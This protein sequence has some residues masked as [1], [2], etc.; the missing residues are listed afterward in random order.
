MRLL[1]LCGLPLPV[2]LEHFGEPR[3]IAQVA[4][5]WVCAHLPP[6]PGIDLHLA[7]LW[8]GGAKRESFHYQGAT[9]HLMPCPARGRALTLFCRDHLY[10]KP[11][12]DE[13]KPDMIH[14]W[15]TE[16]SYGL[17]ALRLGP[18]RNVIG[19][20]GLINEYRRHT[21]MH[22]RYMLTA[23]TERRTLSR[24]R[25]VVAE[26]RYSQEIS[27]PYAPHASFRVVEHPLRREFLEHTPSDGLAEEILVVG[28]IGDRKGIFD[29]LD[30]FIAAAPSS[31]RLHLVGVGP[32]A[33]MER[34]AA[35][36]RE[37]DPE[38]RIRHSPGLGAQ[39][40]AGAMAQASVFLLPT[41]VDTG[42]TA[43]KEALAMG[44]WPVCYDNS[45]PGEYLRVFN[46]GTLVPDLDRPALAEKLGAV[47]RERPWLEAQTRQAGIALARERFDPASVWLR[48]RSV[49]E[50]VLGSARE[51]A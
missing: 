20:Q 49:Y 28:T 50:E 7:C 51:A 17:A 8:P 32:A 36:R 42:P 43:L 4:W 2:E 39:E 41:R 35:W 16:D 37:K 31:W 22:P 1:W 40:L 38:G 44:L 48:L 12:C 29:A 19:I 26:S 11:V 45:G 10:F 33:E 9:F 13:L 27:R 21:A 34:L 18:D 23:V 30:A 46:R 47:L 6:P 24:A 3:G 14:A 5:S 15:G 25:W